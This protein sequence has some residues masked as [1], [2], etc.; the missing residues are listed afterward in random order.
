MR[1][2]IGK[3]LVL[4]LGTVLV[5]VVLLGALAWVQTN[6]LWGQYRQFYEHPFMV[7][8]AIGSL[9]TSILKMRLELREAV[10]AVDEKD[11]IFHRQNSDIYQVAAEHD[12]DELSE[13]F[14]GPRSDVENARSSFAQWVATRAGYWKQIMD[15][16]GEDVWTVL[17]YSGEVENTRQQLLLDLKKIDDFAEDMGGRLY[18]AAWQKK[19][20]L[21]WQLAVGVSLIFLLSGVLIYLLLKSIR[22]PLKELVSVSN[23]FRKGRLEVRSSGDSADE[24]GELSHAFNLMAE[25]IQKQEQELTT[26]HEELALA[27]KYKSEFLANMSHELRTPLNSLLLLAQ[28]LAANREGNLTAAQ[29]ESAKIV[30][31]SGKD[32]LHLINEILDLSKIEAGRMD[33]QTGTV[34]GGELAEKTRHSFERLAREQGIDFDVT[35]AADAPLEIN[36]DFHRVEQIIRNLVSNAIKFTERGNVAVVFGYCSLELDVPCTGPCCRGCLTITV[37]DT[38]IGIAPEQ[39]ETIFKAFRQVDS[40]LTRKYAG[41]GLG[42]T[43][44]RNLASLLGGEV[45]VQSEP[46]QG[47][48]FTLRLPLR[49]DQQSQQFDDRTPQIEPAISS[50]LR[51]PRTTGNGDDPSGIDGIYLET[52]AVAV[53]AEYQKDPDPALQNVKVL[54]VDDDMRNT[55]AVSRLL[56]E[57]GMSPLKAENGERALR[58]LDE[59]PDVAL[60]LMDIMMP[61]MDGWETIDRI[62]GQERFQA[63]PI[64][65]LTAVT[66]YCEGIQDLPAEVRGVLLKPVSADLLLASVRAAVIG[67]Q[68]FDAGNEVSG[69]LHD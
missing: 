60:V 24:F 52:K 1:V 9:E 22:S 11:R 42:L 30:Y 69:G 55:F 38:G 18:R 25:S 14:L 41:T 39:Q 21:Q 8:R 46:G 48:E 3:R 66:D 32:L 13:R 2:S 33:I 12:F 34:K 64:I 27:S 37:K 59:N 63:L 65:V 62:R 31:S 10:L 61:G 43:I 36:S 56:S 49:P 44:S 58:L 57:Q 53:V 16:K 51:P 15:G 35:I 68:G 17:H 5:F 40:T 67:I 47:S 29:I 54:V 4:G 28:E 26:R 20:T 45:L 19:H 50:E 6:I 7:R 23:Q